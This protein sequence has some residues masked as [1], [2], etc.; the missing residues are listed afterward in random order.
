MAMLK[1]GFLLE[2]SFTHGCRRVWQCLFEVQR[3]ISDHWKH[4]EEKLA[5]DNNRVQ[6]SIHSAPQFAAQESAIVARVIR[7]LSA[8][9]WRQT[10]PNHR[11][12][13]CSCIQKSKLKLEPAFL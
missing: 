6:F 4:N 3:A 13:H 11:H 7:T 9:D 10:L 12:P 8:V 2:V 5:R 1:N